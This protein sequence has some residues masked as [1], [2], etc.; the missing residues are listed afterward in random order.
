MPSN[1]YAFAALSDARDATEDLLRPVD[2]GRWLRLALIALFVGVGGGVPTGGS[3]VNVPSGGGGGGMPSDVPAPSLP[4]I[5]S[6]AAVI[7]G[8]V[9]LI[10]LLALVWSLIGA[11]ME[12]VLIVGLRDREVSI[13]DPFGANLRP[14]LRLFGFRLAVGLVSLLVVGLPLLAVFGVGI[15]V[16]PA[17]LI[18]LVPLIVVFGVVALAG[19]VVLGLTTDFV[20]PTMLTESRGVVDG[21]R[22]LWPTLRAEWKQVALYVVAKFVLGI[23]VSLAVSLVVLLAALIVAIPFAIVGGGLYLA[24]SAAGASHVG[25]IVAAVLVALF[26]LVMIVVGLIV[27]VPALTFV[28]YYSLSVLGMLVPELDLVGVER[29]DE[30][31]DDGGDD[32]PNDDDGGDDGPNDDDDGDDTGTGDDFSAPADTV[33]AYPAV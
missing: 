12:F 27:Q 26:V 8:V 10:L 4:D 22:R 9:V 20:V 25:L 19:S 30:E 13:R 18:L 14:G 5:G 17:F 31:S 33:G 2:R 23:A 7:A 29:P 28:R 1:W 16:S 3:N 15:G 6:V 32:G 24:T 11:V 21:W